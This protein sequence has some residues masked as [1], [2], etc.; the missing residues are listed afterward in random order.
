MPRFKVI[1]QRQ[2][3]FAHLQAVGVL[4]R[5]DLAGLTRQHVLFA[6][7]QQVGILLAAHAVPGIEG[8]GLV[9]FFGQARFVERI[10]RFFIGENIAPTRF[11][12]QFIKLLQQALVGRQAFGPRLDLAAYQ[13][14]ADEQLPR[15][16]RVDRAKMHRAPPDQNQA[17]QGDLLIGHD[18]PA[19]FSQCGSKWFFL[20]RWPASGSIQSGSIRHHACIQFGGFDQLG[21][22][23]PLRAL[24]PQA[25]RRVYPAPLASSLV[26]ALFGLV[27]DLAEQ[28]AEEGLVKL[29]VVGR[30]F[31]HRQLQVTA[32]QCQLAMGIAPFAQAQ[33]IEK[34]LAAPV[35]QRVCGQRLALF[36]K[37][38]ATNSPTQ[39]SRSPHPSIA[40]A[41]GPPAG[42][43]AGVRAGAP[44]THW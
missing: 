2:A 21:S 36:F 1:G 44:T 10:Q 16:G 13:A 35:A 22:H 27:A 8:G 3:Q 12:L 26:V 41:P 42:A 7:D 5:R 9:N 19:L 23:H 18:L 20:T 4:G 38:R 37:S 34:V 43:R 25:R 15:G 29:L 24:T 11:G 30:F 39:R 40:R 6:H 33:V 14:L 31:V 28:A 17:V 32:N